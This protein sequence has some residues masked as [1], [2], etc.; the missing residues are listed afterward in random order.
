MQLTVHTFGD[1]GV[2]KVALNY[3]ACHGWLTAAN[4][5]APKDI[6]MGL[7]SEPKKKRNEV[8]LVDLRLLIPSSGDYSRLIRV[9]LHNFLSHSRVGLFQGL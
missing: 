6:Q 8:T 3:V 4:R 2:G 5:C 1:F 9:D 7:K